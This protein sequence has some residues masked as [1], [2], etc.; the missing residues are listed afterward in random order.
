MNELHT[1]TLSEMK[2]FFLNF[3]VYSGKK[4]KKNIKINL[5]EILKK[6]SNM[7]S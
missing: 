7:E 6:I 5:V 4:H 1:E 2:S 3:H